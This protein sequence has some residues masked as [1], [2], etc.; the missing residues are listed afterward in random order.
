MTLMG[1][2]SP[3]AFCISGSCPQNQPPPTNLR[4]GRG[5]TSN[6]IKGFQVRSSEMVD[7]PV[8]TFSRS[9]FSINSLTAFADETDCA[10]LALDRVYSWP[11]FPWSVFNQG[12]GY[13]DFGVGG[14]G[15]ECF[16]EGV[17]HFFGVSFEE[18]A[19]AGDEEG[20]ACENYLFAFVFKE[21]AY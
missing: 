6:R 14:K 10:N 13:I 5:R 7:F 18:A 2:V 4:G 15:A 21:V 11:G 1:S 20:V 17:V 16:V 3:V 8:V 9:H 19:A 12:G